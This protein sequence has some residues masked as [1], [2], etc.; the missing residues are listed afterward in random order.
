M[1]KVYSAV[2]AGGSG[3]RMG[4]DTPK[5]FLRIAGKPIIEHTI[6][7][8]DKLDEIDEILVLSNKNYIDE[9]KKIVNSMTLHKPISVYTGGKERNDTSEKALDIIL[10]KG[11]E[12][13][14]ILFHDAVRPFIDERSI[15]AT[16]DALDT[17]DCVD[18]AI[19]SAD[20][21]VNI[22]EDGE[23]KSIPNR[24]YLLRGQTPQGFRA[25]TLKDAYIKARQDANFFA[26]DDCGVVLKYLPECKIKV[27]AGSDENIKITHPLDLQIADKIFQIRKKKIK[28]NDALIQEKLAGKN[29]VIFGG[30]RG[31][32]KAISDE[33][34]KHNAN[35]F[36]LSRSE[37][38]TDVSSSASIVEGMKKATEK[39]DK[40]DI[41]IVTAGILTKD[42]LTSMTDEQVDTQVLTN[43]LAPAR[44][45]RASYK[46]LKETS[47]ELILFASSSYTRGRAEYSLYSATKAGVVNFT[48]ALSEEWE[49]DNIRVN[50]VSPS[51]TL[52]DM[53][54][55]SFGKEDPNTLLKPQK[56]A[57]KTL[58][59]I[60]SDLTGQIIDVRV[61]EE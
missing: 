31:I 13:A 54:I 22:N 28:H 46:H 1:N 18:V 38:N 61:G 53:R 26:T 36:S 42:N 29:V 17:Y 20:T 52:T 35:V 47:G 48:Q 7:V 9:T 40:I 39:F 59:T 16:I 32:G 58:D 3:E 27:V 45:A 30:S 44:I 15:R 10:A 14:K 37:T 41:V 11:D 34:K 24:N 33:L 50:C 6:E 23:I 4:V 12:N 21:I 2:L 25:K 57:E 51:R 8:F 56:V 60:V 55:E 43:L 49:K 5:Q 19:S